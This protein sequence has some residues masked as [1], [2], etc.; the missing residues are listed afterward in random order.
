[1]LG[2]EGRGSDLEVGKRDEEGEGL[3]KGGIRMLAKVGGKEEEKWL[4]KR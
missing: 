4:K 1:M 2:G 3:E